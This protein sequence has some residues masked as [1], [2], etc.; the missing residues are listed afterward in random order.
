MLDGPQ[1]ELGQEA[2]PRHHPG[3]DGHHVAR[4]PGAVGQASRRPA[5]RRRSPAPPPRRRP[6][7]CRGRASCSA[8]SVRRAAGVGEEHDV[9]AQLPEQQ[10][11]VHRHR[12]GGQHADRLVADLPAV[13]VRAV[14]DVAAPALAQSRDVRAARRPARW[15]PAAGVRRPPGRRP[16]H[17]EAVRRRR[18][19]TSTVPATT[20]PPYAAD[21]RAAA[22][23]QLGR[24]HAVPA[25]QPVDALGGS[26]CAAA[27]A[28]TTATDRRDR[29]SI[30]APFS[31][32]G[33]A[34]DH[35]HVVSSRSAVDH[36]TTCP[37]VL[38]R[39]RHR[40]QASLPI[41]QTDGHGRRPR[42]GPRRRRPPAARAAPA[43][44]DHPGRPVGRRPASR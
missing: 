21:L 34:A 5:G 29:A 3:R 40:W 16:A 26:R 17:R 7:G 13:A 20:C 35:H 33:A 41:W 42:P 38:R 39:L 28:S 1:P 30:S 2:G 43:A 44:R 10:R 11:L 8:C 9:G 12:A 25:E 32:A 24:R 4:R 27:P 37:R 23:E 15:S 31:P 36:C 19:P 6:R 14:H 18:S 22:L